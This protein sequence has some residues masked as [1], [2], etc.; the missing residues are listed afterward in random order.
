MVKNEKYVGLLKSMIACVNHGDY[1]SIKEL[2]NLELENWK[3]EEQK[4]K[5]E[6]KNM[7][8]SFGECK[9]KPLEEWKKNEL[10][11][12]IKNYSYYV[13]NKVQTELISIE[14]FIKIMS[15]C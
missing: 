4:V 1:Y 6:I 13:M 9:D 11:N 5:K 12:L 7:K 15:K 8:F 10:I 14:E 2:S 3:K